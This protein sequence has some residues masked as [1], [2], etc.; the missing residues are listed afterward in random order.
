MHDEGAAAR[1][2]DHVDE[3]VEAGLCVLVVDA[4]AA[5]DGDRQT[6]ARA[7]RRDTFADEL[8]LGHEA[9]AE[10]PRLHAVRGATDIEVDLVITVVRA[11]P[12]RGCEF[13]RIAAAELKRERTLGRREPEHA[14]A[15]AVEHRVGG[16][17]LGIEEGPLGDEPQEIAAVAVGPL[18]HR[19]DGKAVGKRHLS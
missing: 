4:D 7:H 19:R 5:L 2:R 18:H 17:H 10:P 16:D 12:R 6:G 9:G 11:D 14:R 3:A 15:V 1:A 8:G 13:L